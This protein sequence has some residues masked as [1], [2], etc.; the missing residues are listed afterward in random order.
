MKFT[1]QIG[2]TEKHKVSYSFNKFIGNVK[3]MV[4]NKTIKRD[5][6]M[7]SFSQTKDYD[8]TIGTSEKHTV[9]IQ[10]YR[11]LFAAGMRSNSYRVFVDGTLFKEFRD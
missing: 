4:D 11:P 8:F 7:Y 5:F 3:I 9:K 6:R 1:V 2:D 10:K